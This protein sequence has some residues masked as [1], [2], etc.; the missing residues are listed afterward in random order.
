MGNLYVDVAG[1]REAEGWRAGHNCAVALLAAPVE[2]VA[3]VIDARLDVELFGV[4]AAALRVCGAPTCWRQVACAWP[5]CMK[6]L[7]A[8]DA[9]KPVEVA[10]TV[11]AHVD[12]VVWA[13]FNA[14]HLSLHKQ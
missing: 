2:D 8:D 13:R 9:V 11:V 7:A 3:A 14:G 10:V 12:G 5:A 6:E 4:A 1:V